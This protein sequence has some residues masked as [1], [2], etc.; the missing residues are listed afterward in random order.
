MSERGRRERMR[1][2]GRY[3]ERKEAR[4]RERAW[5]EMNTSK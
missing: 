3:N 4:A 5:N 1:E 2:K